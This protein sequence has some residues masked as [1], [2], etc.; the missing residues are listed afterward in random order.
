MPWT[1]KYDHSCAKRRCIFL[2]RPFIPAHYSN[3]LLYVLSFSYLLKISILIF[4]ISKRKSICNRTY[5]YDSNRTC[6]YLFLFYLLYSFLHLLHC[7]SLNFSTDPLVL[8]WGPLEVPR[9]Q[10]KTSWLSNHSLLPS[11]SWSESLSIWLS[12]FFNT[13]QVVKVWGGCGRWRGKV[14]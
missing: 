3:A 4:V 1:A 8:P 5:K 11:E 12:L 7:F 9:S 14:E 10:F 6:F 13:S 2:Q